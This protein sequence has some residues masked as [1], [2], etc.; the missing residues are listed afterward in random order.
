[1]LGN[2]GH[3][4]LGDE[5]ILAGFVDATRRVRP[6][7]LPILVFSDDP[8]DTRS[9]MDERSVRAVLFRRP[10]AG[11]PWRL[12]GILSD[13]ISSLRRC[14]N[15]VLA[16]GGLLNDSNPTSL[17]LYTAIA[18]IAPFIGTRVHAVAISIGPLETSRGRALARVLL[19]R[20]AS[21]SV[22]DA[23]SL[24][25][26]HSLGRPDA[27]RVPDAALAMDAW[28]TRSFARGLPAAVRTIA[29]SVIPLGKPGAWYRSNT[30]EYE[31]YLR[32]M[33]GLATM[34]VRDEGVRVVL[35]PINSIHDSAAGAEILERIAPEDQPY[36][37][38]LRASTV[39][40][41][42]N[43]L[44]RADMLVACRLHSAVLATV[45]GR[46]F[47]TL[48]Y[49]DKVRS[50]A[51][52][53]G[54][55]SMVVDVRGVGLQECRKLLDDCGGSLT[56]LAEQVAGHAERAIPEFDAGWRG[57]LD[58]IVPTSPS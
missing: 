32:T 39:G 17:L 48:A 2:Y 50:Y 47:V 16:G 41:V 9:R 19:R 22:R 7:L 3:R 52:D 23:D 12:F 15:L 20:L 18:V 5:A 25:T 27:T 8:I 40:D 4:N 37:E 58:E 11:R 30:A 51:V 46:P 57:L 33:A 54:L 43:A 31:L 28:E 56:A 13:V 42:L 14:R 24:R 49:Q 55:G 38:L 26:A 45:V 6:D 1:L 35:V 21:V 44:G 53:A 36:C 10:L 34:L 29:V